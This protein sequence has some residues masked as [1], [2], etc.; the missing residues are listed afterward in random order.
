[1]QASSGVFRA[2]YREQPLQSAES[3][4]IL[5]PLYQ[6]INTIYM[7]AHILLGRQIIATQDKKLYQEFDAPGRKYLE[8]CGGKVV[9]FKT[10]DGL[11][12]EGMRFIGKKCTPDSRTILLCN[13]ARVRYEHNQ[14]DVLFDVRQ[15]LEKGSNVF[16]FNYRGVGNSEGEATRDGLFLDAEAAMQYLLDEKKVPQNKVI[17]HGH[18]VGGPVGAKIAADYGASYCNDR[19]FISL[20]KHAKEAHGNGIIGTIIEKVIVALNW[21]QDTMQY[22]GS[23]QGR[24]WI[25]HHPQDKTTRTG[26]FATLFDGKSD[27][28]PIIIMENIGKPEDAHTRG[29]KG[30]QEFAAYHA[31]ID[32]C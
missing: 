20:S 22:W 9:K 3:H 27:A 21:E 16:L 7:R 18:S 5:R 1:M 30:E 23:I 17:V 31:Q 28:P 6:L 29:L 12:L 8:E 2:H 15:W 11:V 32:L 26:G 25:L 4:F 14:K 19:S 24:K 13:G 10:A